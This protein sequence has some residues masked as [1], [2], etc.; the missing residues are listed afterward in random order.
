MGKWYIISALAAERQYILPVI[1]VL[2]SVVSAGYYLPVVM[3]MYMRPAPES[4]RYAGVRLAPAAL[5]AIALSV[6]VV[7]LFGVWPGPLLD[8]AGQSA[9]T[10]TQTGLPFAGP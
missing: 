3:A 10:L 4:E 1:L 9:L 7:L 8:I 5:G 6:A 2:T